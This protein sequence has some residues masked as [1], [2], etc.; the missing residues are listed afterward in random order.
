MP[1][2]MYAPIRKPITALT[3][4]TN[5]E[6]AAYERKKPEINTF[7]SVEDRQD[8]AVMPTTAKTSAAV[9]RKLP[10]TAR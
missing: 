4:P 10:E 3:S 6:N 7:T 9:M 8:S 5:A 2:G 1:S